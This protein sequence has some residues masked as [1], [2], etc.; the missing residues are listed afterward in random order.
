MALKL[1]EDAN[2]TNVGS[3]YSSDEKD[4]SSTNKIRSFLW[5]CFITQI[6]HSDDW[7]RLNLSRLQYNFSRFRSNAANSLPANSGR[8]LKESFR[9]LPDRFWLKLCRKRTGT[10]WKWSGFTLRS[11]NPF[12]SFPS[13]IWNDTKRSSYKNVQKIQEEKGNWISKPVASSQVKGIF[14]THSPRWGPPVDPTIF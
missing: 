9:W 3:L 6:N 8:K 4:H 14:L 10:N 11:L 13:I 5:L 2:S 1:Y 12:Q 7:I